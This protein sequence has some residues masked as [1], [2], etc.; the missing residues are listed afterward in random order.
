ME[1]SGD[2]VGESIAVEQPGHLSQQ[3]QVPVFQTLTRE[4][5]CCCLACLGKASMEPKAAPAGPCVPRGSVPGNTALLRPRL[6][7]WDFT[8]SALLRSS[9]TSEMSQLQG[10][11]LVNE[12][13]LVFR[14]C[15]S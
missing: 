15:S 12:S 3:F 1:G 6:R 13:N 8:P 7:S 9:A 4:Q 2:A 14:T 5:H 10:G 11:I